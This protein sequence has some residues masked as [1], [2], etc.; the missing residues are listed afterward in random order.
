MPWKTTLC[1]LG[2]LALTGCGGTPKASEMDAQ[3]QGA[4]VVRL[5][6]DA[7]G[8][9]GLYPADGTLKR[10]AAG[11]MMRSRACG[12]GVAKGEIEIVGA[13]AGGLRTG[14]WSLP[15]SRQFAQI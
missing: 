3:G 14:T 7:S 2:G 4:S 11:I 1:L 10:L 8:R 12:A 5:S 15:V 6:M 13:Y 9:V